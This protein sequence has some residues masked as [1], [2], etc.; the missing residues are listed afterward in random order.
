MSTPAVI[1][2]SSYLDMFIHYLFQN[3]LCS[4][5]T[6]QNSLWDIIHING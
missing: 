6:S 3:S 5:L 2:N 1:R 4:I